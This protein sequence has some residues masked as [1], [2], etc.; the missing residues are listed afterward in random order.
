MAAC[1][2][3]RTEMDD[4]TIRFDTESRTEL[5]IV[6]PVTTRSGDVFNCV[7]YNKDLPHE[8]GDR[9]TSA[10]AETEDEIRPTVERLLSE[11]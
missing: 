5:V 2:Y 4:G 6:T 11:L 7:V 1:E 9:I 8:Y 3:D 10:I